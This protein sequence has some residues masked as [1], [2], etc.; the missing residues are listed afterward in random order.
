M[1]EDTPLRTVLDDMRERTVDRRAIVVAALAGGAAWVLVEVLG[2][3]LEHHKNPFDT[4]VW[5]SSLLLGDS[6]LAAPSPAAFVVLGLVLHAMLSLVYGLL[7]CL[8]VRHLSSQR[9]LI[10]GFVFALALYI[11]NYHLLTPLFPVFRAARG[12]VA[13]LAHLAFGFFVVVTMLARRP[14]GEVAPA[15]A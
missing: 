7:L 8:S 4:F 6:V 9:A 1:N 2:R 15:P 5:I 3:A 14:I 12:G 13:I 10:W 11:V